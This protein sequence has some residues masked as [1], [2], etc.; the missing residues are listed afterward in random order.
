[1]GAGQ[2]VSPGLLLSQPVKSEPARP[3]GTVSTQCSPIKMKHLLWMEDRKVESG[4]MLFL[5]VFMGGRRQ[6]IEKNHFLKQM[7]WL[8]REGELWMQMWGDQRSQE[9]MWLWRE[10]ALSLTPGVPWVNRAL[11]LSPRSPSQVTEPL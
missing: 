2:G 4:R 10:A 7:S 1:M 9:Q 3:L 6:R 8:M 5:S 11:G